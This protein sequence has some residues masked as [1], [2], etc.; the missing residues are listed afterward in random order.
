M[1]AAG[2]DFTHNT[3]E[4]AALVRGTG[5]GLVMARHA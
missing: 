1:D 4:E 5:S 3:A 2:A